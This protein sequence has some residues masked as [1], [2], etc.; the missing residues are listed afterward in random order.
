MDRINR[1][2]FFTFATSDAKGFLHN[3]PSAPALEIGPRGTDCGTGSGSA[4]QTDPGLETRGEPSRGTD[5]DPRRIPGKAP[6][7][8]TCAGQGTGMATNAPFHSRCSKHLHAELLMH[9]RATV[10]YDGSWEGLWDLFKKR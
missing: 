10:R 4:R 7:H 8:Q 1:T 5:A 9:W 3:D 6:V 2:G